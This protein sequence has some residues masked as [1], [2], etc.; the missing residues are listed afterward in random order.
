VLEQLT[1]DTIVTPRVKALIADYSRS[2]NVHIVL[3][4]TFAEMFQYVWCRI[5]THPDAAEIKRILNTDM[6]EVEHRCFTGRISKL[7]NVL[8]G[9]YPDVKIAIS[10]NEQIAQIVLLTKGDTP[11]AHRAAV[12]AEMTARGY[13]AA[14]IAHWTAF[15]E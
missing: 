10:D 13:S 5:Q 1:A 12:A 15:I 4:V 2:N 6:L 3:N 8:N 14:E 9:F 7:V 11:E